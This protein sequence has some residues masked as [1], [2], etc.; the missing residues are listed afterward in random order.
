M[1]LLKYLIIIMSISSCLTL[2]TKLKQ[3]QSILVS[4]LGIN[5][6]T[7]I[8]GLFNLL[9][10][11]I[12]LI[13]LISGIALIYLIVLLVKEKSRIKQIITLPTIIYIFLLCLTYIFVQK[14]SFSEYDEFMFWGTNLK[15]MVNKNILWANKAFDGIHLTY[16]PFAA[17]NEYVFCQYNGFYSES[18]AYFGMITF[19][20][21][22]VLP[23]F[24][25]K[26]SHFKNVFKVILVY[27]LLYVSV[28]YLGLKLPNIMVDLLLGVNFAVSLY[29]VYSRENRYS[30]LLIILSLIS[31]SLLKA[32]G[33]LLIL[34]ILMYMIVVDVLIAKDKK[35]KNLLYIFLIFLVVVSAL[36]SWKLYCVVN[37]TVTDERHDKHNIQNI[38]VIEFIN[39]LTL[40]RDKCS[41]RNYYLVRDFY[42]K[43]CH[44][45]TSYMLKI[46]PVFLIV[47]FNIIG[48]CIFLKRKEYKTLW[49]YLILDIGFLGYILS[50]ILIYMFVFVEFQGTV[51][52]DMYRYIN[53]YLIA[54]IFFS[55]F[56]INE[57]SSD[58]IHLGEILLLIILLNI[59][60]ANIVNYHVNIIMSR[61]ITNAEFMDS[62]YVKERVKKTEKVFIIDTQFDGGISFVKFRYLI[63]PIQTNLLYE[64]NIT[65]EKPQIYYQTRILEKDFEDILTN[66]DYIYFYNVDKKFI[67]EYSQLFLGLEIESKS[68]LKI[69]V[70]DN[71]VNLSLVE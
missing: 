16:Q 31:L 13:Y 41:E 29:L 68:L 3:E 8:L 18:S 6:F 14:L 12:F 44:E 1:Y 23:I 30:Y 5:I 38:D 21:T 49:I 55:V 46:S 42:H 26:D 37:N 24:K 7:Y 60:F 64:W 61:E 57:E 11:S 28:M 66:Y 47:I 15:T 2:K 22:L 17:I 59:N 52:M 19:L 27:L 56:V 50:V 54:Y 25:D 48:I 40:Q 36:I 65:T 33:I 63:A 32:N 34:I 67:S 51:L 4:F 70:T 69:D 58:Y 39:A 35:S 20:I 71:K 10:Y 53:M 62:V 43:L 45:Q 9:K